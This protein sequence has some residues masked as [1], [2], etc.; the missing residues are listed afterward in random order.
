MT[1]AQDIGDLLIASDE[2]EVCTDPTG[3]RGF[4]NHHPLPQRP[5]LAWGQRPG[6]R[7]FE[8]SPPQV[9]RG[10]LFCGDPSSP[11]LWGAAHP[12][13]CLCGDGELTRSGPLTPVPEGLV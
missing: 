7:D 4:V 3:H 6:K 11:L 8:R 12:I 13:W 5:E 9:C 10:E 1:G 2:V